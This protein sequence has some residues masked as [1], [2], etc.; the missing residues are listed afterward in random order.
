[1][2]YWEFRPPPR[3][4]Q[5]F[6]TKAEWEARYGAENIQRGE[7]NAKMLM[8]KENNPPIVYEYYDH[9]EH[10]VYGTTLSKRITGKR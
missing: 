9:E 6:Y 8:E 10:H 4:D 2:A 5:D 7:A 1:M 3:P